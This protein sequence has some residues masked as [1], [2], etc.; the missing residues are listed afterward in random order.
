MS[1]WTGIWQAKASYDSCTRISVDD[2]Q[3][4][5]L[6]AGFRAVRV[7][8]VTPVFSPP[9]FADHFRWSEIGIAGIKVLLQK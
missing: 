9:E 1:R 3:R 6:T 2:L 4:A 8:L 5:C 7:E